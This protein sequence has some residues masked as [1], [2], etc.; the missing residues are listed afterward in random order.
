MKGYIRDGALRSGRV[1]ETADTTTHFISANARWARIIALRPSNDEITRWD[2]DRAPRS[3][4]LL[5]Q[6]CRGRGA[7]PS[8]EIRRDAGI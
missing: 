3:G 2:V 8:I 7:L 1:G 5:L 6:W 4:G